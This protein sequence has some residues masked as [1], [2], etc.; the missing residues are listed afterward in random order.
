[1]V[2]SI[3]LWR[4]L[5]P[6]LMTWESKGV[7]LCFTGTYDLEINAHAK[8]ALY[9]DPRSNDLSYVIWDLSQIKVLDFRMTQ[10]QF[11]AMRDKISSERIP[12][13]RKGFIVRDTPT[14]QLCER[15]IEESHALGLRWEFR[16][17]SDPDVIREWVK[18]LPESG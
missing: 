7:V 11:T 6:Y 15:Y 16:I 5:L 2:A 13:L 8:N 4:V 12:S 10:T 1:M 17:S 14:A 3:C 9:S 18:S